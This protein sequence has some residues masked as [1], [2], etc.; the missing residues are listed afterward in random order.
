M[1]TVICF[2]FLAIAIIL[3]GFA[4][5]GVARY[6]SWWDTDEGPFIIM[7]IFGIIAVIAWLGTGIAVLCLISD[8]HTASK[9]DNQIAIVESANEALETRICAAVEA[10]MQ[11]EENIFKNLDIDIAIGLYSAYPN[12]TSNELIQSLITTYQKNTA[13]IKTL[14][15]KQSELI[16]VKYLVYFGN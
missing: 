13:E 11:H 2:V 14:R 9:Y 4:F 16:T 3:F 1:L 8:L 10:N 6:D 7:T 15:M 5:G 12:L